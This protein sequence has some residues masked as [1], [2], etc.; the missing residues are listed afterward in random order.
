YG[1]LPD[2]G[3]PGA[4]LSSYARTLTNQQLRFHTDRCDVVGLFCIRQAL[5]GGIS[6]LCSSPAVHNAI[7]TRRP[8]L[9][10][11]LYEPL[12]RS[13]FGEEDAANDTAYALPV[14]GVR[15]GKFTS[16]YSRTFIEAAQRRLEAPLLSAALAEG[17][18]LLHD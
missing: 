12:W 7:L 2:A 13:R 5:R 11:A 14:R 8:E 1:A 10:A 17:L 6:K 18:D 3:R 4:F 16:H 15:D 9:C